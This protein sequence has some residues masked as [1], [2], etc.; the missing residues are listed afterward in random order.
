MRLLLGRSGLRSP[1]TTGTTVRRTSSGI[2]S[3]TCTSRSS[4]SAHRGSAATAAR[5]ID[6]MLLLMS[7]ALT[8]SSESASCRRVETPARYDRGHQSPFRPPPRLQQPVPLH[9]LR[10]VHAT[11]RNRRF[12]RN[13]MPQATH[14]WYT[15][16]SVFR[17]AGPPCD[18]ASTRPAWHRGPTY[19]NDGPLRWTRTRSRATRIAQAVCW[20]WAGR[21]PTQ[22]ES[23]RCS[24]PSLTQPC[25]SASSARGANSWTRRAPNGGQPR[26]GT[27]RSGC[28]G[29]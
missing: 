8:S 14:C 20:K 10:H 13:L 9:G 12:G 3:L 7:S 5:T 22:P 4:Q 29:R 19:V 16:C 23:S 17:P 28:R 24:L 1:S 6:A 2:Y 18:L 27:T 21:A 11:T 25:P 15:A 26:R